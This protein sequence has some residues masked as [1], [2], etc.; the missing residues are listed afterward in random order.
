L[1]FSGIQNY[2]DVVTRALKEMHRQVG[3]LKISKRGI[4]QRG[5]LIRHLVLP[6]DT[7]GSKK[8][9]DFIADEISTNSYL[10][11]MDQYRPVYNANK[12]EKLNRKITP[13]EYKEVV[14]YAFSKGLRRGFE[15]YR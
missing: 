10:N 1:K 2:W 7:A 12:Y 9:I 5:L 6:N 11:I 13:S 15:E 8:V 3:D 4:A 14:D